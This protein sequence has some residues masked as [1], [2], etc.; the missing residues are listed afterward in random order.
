ML[1]AASTVAALHGNVDGWLHPLYGYPEHKTVGEWIGKHSQP[2]DL[3][4]STNIVPGYYAHRDTVPIP[5]AQPE[6]IVA[7]GR[8]YGVRFLIA[9]QAHGTRFRP[10]LRKLIPRTDLTSL[11][12]VYRTTK[13]ERKTIV[14]EI[15]PRPPRFNGRVPLLDLG[16]SR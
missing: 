7:F 9:D 2:D 8:H 4:M 11:R 6:K 16:E 14:Y 15:V 13:D 3:I 5:W 1:V 10:Q 12:P